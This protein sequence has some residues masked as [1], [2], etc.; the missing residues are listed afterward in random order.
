MAKYKLL[1][2]AF[3]NNTLFDEGAVVEVADDFEPGSH[4]VPMDAA[5][6]KKA[7]EV[8]LVNAEVPDFVDA[9]TG[10]VNVAAY[11]AS[12]QRKSG[13]LSDVAVSDMMGPEMLQTQ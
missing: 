5:A 10:G 4:M 7:K 12:P 2:R 6:K 1:Q 9:M 3:I 11:G 13:V 8:C